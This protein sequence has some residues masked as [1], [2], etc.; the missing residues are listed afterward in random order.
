MNE[1]RQNGFHFLVT[2]LCVLVPVLLVCLGISDSTMQSMKKKEI[3]A[4][5]VKLNRTANVLGEQY[6]RFQDLSAIMAN[7]SE[8]LP[9]RMT[10]EDDYNAIYVGLDVIKDIRS[11]NSTM[12][13][14]FAYYGGSYVYGS[15]GRSQLTVYLRDTLHCT[16]K[17]IETYA[18]KLNS[19]EFSAFFVQGTST[20]GSVVLHYPVRF[21]VSEGVTAMNFTVSQQK[22]G[23]LL[24]GIGETD[25][26]FLR[27]TFADGGIAYYASNGR[28][29]LQSILAAQYPS[30]D[31]LERYTP[32]TAEST[33]LGAE[34]ELLYP[35]Q[36]LLRD[37]RKT[38]WTNVGLISGGA[39]LS[40]LLAFFISRYW[41]KKIRKIEDTFEGE[42]RDGVESSGNLESIYA[43]IVNM[44]KQKQAWRD[45]DKYSRE[46][47]QRQLASM[48]FQ[49]ILTD[50][51]V[52]RELMDYCG[53]TMYDKGYIIG[54]IQMTCDPKGYADFLRLMRGDL[55]CELEVGG[56][57]TLVFLLDTPTADLSQEYR[58]GTAQR[59]AQ[60]VE[61]FGGTHIRIAMS[62]V[63]VRLGQ[64]NAAFLEVCDQLGEMDT[65]SAALQIQCHEFASQDT[66]QSP[67]TAA[68]LDEYTAAVT[69]RNMQE[70]VRRF[71][72]IRNRMAESECDAD[73]LRFL[74]YELVQRTMRLVEASDDTNRAHL[75]DVLLHIDPADPDQLA[76]VETVIRR[77]CAEDSAD[78]F[79]RVVAYMKQNFQ[80]VDLTQEEVADKVGLSRSFVSRVFQT[81]GGTGYL[82]YLTEMRLKKARE[83]LLTTDLPVTEVFRRVGYVSRNNY[84]QRF[85]E[86]FGVSPSDMRRNKEMEIGPDGTPKDDIAPSDRAAAVA[87]GKKLPRKPDQP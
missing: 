8:L 31:A 44:K 3:N 20:S 37:V 72:S 69:Q 1:K 80:R 48:I 85:K 45:H 29:Q 61:L 26:T 27:M 79:D 49:G 63:C 73:L 60:V 74:R 43:M 5:Q 66:N 22:W 51:A 71:R 54:G 38:Q 55:C 21:V 33:I 75:R 39:L 17:E 47:I 64:A 50:P 59:L 6:T 34:L 16:E 13:D 56:T 35:S 46:T 57:N 70:A 42:D 25:D 28:G 67:I 10:N 14:L 52:A 18:G 19:N 65:A 77:H 58:I 41:D 24:T 4:I 76:D 81:R 62:R 82:D 78:K 23:E 36:Q 32:L 7:T 84:S 86:F 15:R 2:Y 68:E 83:L 40:L 53:L 87:Q 11:Y 12:L 30:D 9:V